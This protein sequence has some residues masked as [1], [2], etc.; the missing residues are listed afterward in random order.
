MTIDC[1]LREC[2][3]HIRK[4]AG[5]T[6]LAALETGAWLETAHTI[7]TGHGRGG[8]WSNWLGVNVPFISVRTA[9]RYRRIYRRFRESKTLV[10][11]FELSALYELVKGSTPEKAV[12]HALLEAQ[13]GSFVTARD[14]KK[15]VRTFS[16]D[17]KKPRRAR[18][19]KAEPTQ[20]KV[21][22]GTVTVETFGADVLGALEE[23][24]AQLREQG[25][26]DHSTAG[27]DQR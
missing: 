22:G 23:A 13:S 8:R 19:K 4:S 21:T 6:A 12:A 5:R 18:I 25:A 27:K 1:K 15:I 17:E 11:C 14:A 16:T 20:L 9:D 3:D 10:S 7:H 2:A 24:I 26:I